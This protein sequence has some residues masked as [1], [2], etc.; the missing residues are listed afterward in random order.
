MLFGSAIFAQAPRTPSELPTI[1]TQ[2][3][4]AREQN[5]TQDAVRLYRESVRLQPNWSEGWWYLGTLFYDQ[6]SFAPARVALTKLVQLEPQAPPA[7]WALLGLCEF[8]TKHF[9]ESLRHLERSFIN[10]ARDNPFARAARYHA[11]LLLT[12]TG[13]FEA[14]LKRLAEIAAPD[15]ESP[16]LIRAIGVAGLRLALFA[17][18]LPVAQQPSADQVGHALFNG[19]VR[20]EK[21]AELEYQ[22]LLALYPQRPELHHLHGVALLTSDPTSAIEELK[23]EIAI[24]PRHVAARLQIAFEYLK[25][26]DAAKA[27]PF[28][29]E[30]D[31]LEPTSFAAHAAL[32]QAF[33]DLDDLP[34][35]ILELEKA[36]ALAPDSP[37]THM[38]L[39][40]AYAKAGRE[41]EA[42][43]ERE[44]FLKL[45]SLAQ[46]R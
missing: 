30:A 5:R 36:R 41:K 38:K 7:A 33:V 2:A 45:R 13:R 32:G 15:S 8:E 10:E 11:A 43:Q 44:F 21:E 40:S 28:A 26:G 23:R 46:R 6:N 1:Q 24:S 35:G 9:P 4:Q 16:E 42:A 22:A 39:A 29:R 14:A 34:R 27:L 17:T 25:Q 12:K 3:T 20:R 37:E 19:Y 18:E 31:A